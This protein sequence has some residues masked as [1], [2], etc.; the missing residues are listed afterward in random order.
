MQ[1]RRAT[2]CAALATAVLIPLSAVGA[3]AD[4]VPGYPGM[5]KYTADLAP[6]T[7][8]RSQASG[9]ATIWLDD[10]TAHVRITV[11]DVLA[12]HP[13]AQHIH[14]GGRGECPTDYDAG[15]H[16]GK[17]ALS[18]LDGLEAYGGVETSITTEG[19]TSA[20]SAL[21]IDRFPTAPDGMI[22]YDRT[23]E[24]SQAAADAVRA[25]NAVV[26]IH[27][28]DY[29]GDGTYG[30]VLGPSDLDPNLPMEATN[31][32]ACGPLV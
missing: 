13:H 24:L 25:G 28:I 32:A 19:D 23:F 16:N 18:T 14:I 21:A 29:D 31:P 8:N 7:V 6:V 17:R 10:T 30:D 5:E 12:D 20:A 2:T 15:I 11:D 22:D 26:V 3:H 1:I 4:D 9:T 27:G